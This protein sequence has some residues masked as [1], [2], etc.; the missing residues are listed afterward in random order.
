MTSTLRPEIC[1]A[2][3][4]G[5][6][7]FTSMLS[8]YLLR[9][10]RQWQKFGPP[11]WFTEKWWWAPAALCASSAGAAVVLHGSPAARATS[12]IA[13]VVVL[14]SL[15]FPPG[16]PRGPSRSTP[17]GRRAES[18]RDS[19]QWLRS[20]AVLLALVLQVIAL[21]LAETT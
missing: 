17:S 5:L 16:R 15:R 9:W 2:V 14:G 3:V 4:V 18:I 11:R 8:A 13:L 1:E 20:V 12:L 6:L 7:F 10:G 19:W 21:A